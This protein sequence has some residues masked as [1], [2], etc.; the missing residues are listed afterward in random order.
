V[1][2]SFPDWQEVYRIPVD[3]LEIDFSHL[4]MLRHEESTKLTL[5]GYV[6]DEAI[7]SVGKVMEIETESGLHAPN[8]YIYVKIAK[9]AAHLGQRYLMVKDHG[10]I[11]QLNPQIDDGIN[12]HYV[13]IY[14]EVELTEVAHT[15]S[16][17]KREQHEMEVYRAL[18]TQSL[19]LPL[20]DYDLIPGKVETFSTVG[21]GPRGNV[22]AQLIGS[23]KGYASAVYGVNDIVFI[24]K[25]SHQGVQVGQMLDLY[26]DR[27]IRDDRASLRFGNIRSGYIKIVRVSGDCATGVII[28]AVDSIQQGDRAVGNPGAQQTSH[29][30]SNAD[31]KEP[32]ESTD[33]VPPVSSDA[34]DLN[35]LQGTPPDKSDGGLELSE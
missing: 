29:P 20:T 15:L 3:K 7:Q 6:Q 1:P 8:E 13:Q 23:T 26:I 18:L 12:A 10:V 28:A 27:T 9:G 17:I 11:R 30:E 5:N 33:E 22:S 2:N 21:S 34:Q 14:G 19:S 24:D 32:S 35:D 25:G 4:N 31:K 16:G